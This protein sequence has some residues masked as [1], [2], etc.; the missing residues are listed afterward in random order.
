M[1][2]NVASLPATVSPEPILSRR[3]FEGWAFW[4]LDS[5]TYSVLVTYT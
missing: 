5:T 2:D 3:Q 1:A 4:T